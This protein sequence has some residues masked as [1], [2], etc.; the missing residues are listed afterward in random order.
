MANGVSIGRS[1]GRS[2]PDNAGRTNSLYAAIPILRPRSVGQ[3]SELIV[4]VVDLYVSFVGE[5]EKRAFET[6][7]TNM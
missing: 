5:Q 1:V 3:S 2:S 6:D 7:A 4:R